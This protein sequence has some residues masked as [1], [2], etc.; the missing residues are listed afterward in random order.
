[1]RN[2]VRRTHEKAT[3]SGRK[4]VFLLMAISLVAAACGGGDD[5]PAADDPGGQGDQTEQAAGGE[6]LSAEAQAAVDKANELGLN[7]VTSREEILK[8]AEAEGKVVVQTSTDEFQAF[9]EAF[10]AEYPFIDMEWTE[11]SGAATERFLLEV[12]GG[13]AGRYDVGYPAPEAYDTIADMMNWDLY[14]MAE[15]GVLDIPL[16]TIDAERRTVVAAGHT[17][18][19]LAYNKDIVSEADLPKT[20]EDLLDPKWSR[21]EL[22][23]SLDV[24]LNNVSVLAAHPDWGIDRVAELMSGIAALDP[25]YTDGHSSAAKLVA[26]GE[27]AISPFINLH[28]SMRQVDKD[29]E[30]PLQVTFIEPVPIRASEAYGVFSDDLSEAPYAAL[31]FIE[32]IANNDEAQAL[33]DADPLQASLYWDESRMAEMIGDRETAVADP[34]GVAEL[35]AWIQQIQEAAGF[36]TAVDEG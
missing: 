34:A 6:E 31:L 15:L 8:G 11:L 30:G 1:M 29:P 10:E 3:S 26:S 36:P 19:A 7:I 4:L 2:R 17:G 13:A 18:I 27:V 9:E 14:G 33:L 5:G 12:E 21:G 22:G 35:P 32:W 16:E 20:W 25:I 24:D 28:S 23:M